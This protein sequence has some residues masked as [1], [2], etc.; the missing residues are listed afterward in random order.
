MKASL[1]HRG[2]ITGYSEAA[3]RN[4]CLEANAMIRGLFGIN[5]RQKN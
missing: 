4:M 2:D 3:T 1:K 5:D